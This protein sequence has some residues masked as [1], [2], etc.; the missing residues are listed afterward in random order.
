[1]HKDYNNEEVINILV[2]KFVTTGEEALKLEL[3]DAFTPYFNKYAYILCTSKT[4]D[5]TNKD[6]ITFLRLFMTEEDRATPKAIA[7]SIKQTIQHLR[8]VFSDCTPDDIH[9]E[10]V[11][12]F[13]EQLARY[14]P[15]IA[16]NTPHKNRISF[17][18]FVQVNTRYRIKNL[19]NARGKDALHG[20]YNIEYTEDILPGELQS[21][22]YEGPATIDH[23]WVSGSTAGETFKQLEE[24]ERYLLYL[25]YQDENK[26]PLSEYDL[27][28][29]TGCDRMYVRRKMIKIKDKLKILV[30]A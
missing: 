7:Y 8:M 3:L 27:S 23:K 4:V 21:P 2:D 1:M 30:D 25:K 17:T 5:T 14:R 6:T 13:L 9:D 19:A 20:V 10:M 22:T 29:I 24:F 11:C 28:R 16:N 12:I 15:M 18:H 26:T